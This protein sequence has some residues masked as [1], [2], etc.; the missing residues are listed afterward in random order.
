MTEEQRGLIK[1]VLRTLVDN[2]VASTLWG[3]PLAARVA[4]GAIA[5]GLLFLLLA[6]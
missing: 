2:A 3:L 6:K 4:I 1:S 5:F